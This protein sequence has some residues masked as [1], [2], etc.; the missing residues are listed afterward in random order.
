MNVAVMKT[1]CCMKYVICVIQRRFGSSNN[2]IR[3]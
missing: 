1:T 3:T 2:D